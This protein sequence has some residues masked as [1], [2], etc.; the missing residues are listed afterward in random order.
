[1]TKK[2]R[3]RI[4]QIT[5]V[6]SILQQE[7]NSSCP[8]CNN[9]DVGHF[10]IHHIDE[11][12]DNNEIENLI[13]LCPICHSKITKGDI[14]QSEVESIKR[15]L[16]EINQHVECISITVNEGDC[17]WC[18]FE[19]VENAFFDRRIDK[20][21]FP[22][23]NFSLINNS[24]KTI[25][26][27]GIKLQSKNLFSGLSGFP[28]PTI[29]K[30]IAKYRIQLPNNKEITKFRLPDEIEVPAGR[31]FKFQIELYERRENEEYPINGRK[32]LD[33]IFRFDNLD[34][35]VPTVFLNCKSENEKREI[36]LLG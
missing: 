1:M 21:P 18:N 31:A 12:P 35:R 4:K 11:N 23:L 20:S 19:D 5:K 2:I 15:K 25:L 33:F 14:I 10:E 34:F 32:V 3:T 28:K 7:I 22:I 24:P 9:M 30:S 13:L 26:L 6:R 27:R 8:F 16:P 17:S 29:L 36:R